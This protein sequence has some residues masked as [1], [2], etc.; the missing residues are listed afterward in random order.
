MANNKLKLTR[1]GNKENTGMPQYSLSYKQEKGQSITDISYEILTR[2]KNDNDAVIEINSSLTMKTGGNTDFQPEKL[3][4]E[5]RDLDL[6]YSYRKVKETKNQGFINSLF[7]GKKPG[8]SHEIYVYIPGNIWSIDLFKR[9]S[10]SFGVRYYIMRKSD[11][12][13]NILDEMIR[14]TDNEKADHFE[15]II[16]DLTELKRMGIISNRHSFEDIEKIL[17]IM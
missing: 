11:E 12:G 9:I 14:M 10:P 2:L 7:M 3:L 6:V 5:I 17:G 15:Y 1:T 8:D 16:F 4:A 13:S